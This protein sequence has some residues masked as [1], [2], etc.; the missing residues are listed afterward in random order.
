MSAYYVQDTLPETANR[1][2]RRPGSKLE[3]VMA[4]GGEIHILQLV[5]GSDGGI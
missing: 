3:N 5:G 1:V 4:R 2:A